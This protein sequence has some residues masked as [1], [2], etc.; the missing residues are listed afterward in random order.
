MVTIDYRDL[1]AR[2][3][4]AAGAE[5]GGPATGTAARSQSPGTRDTRDAA[6]HRARHRLHGPEDRLRRGHHPRRPRRRRTGSW[7]SAG[8][9]GSSRR[10]SAKPS[11][12]GTRAAPSPAAPS[13]HPGAKP[14][15]S[16]T[17]PAAAPPAPTTATLLC[18]HHHHVIH[19]EHWS[20]QVRTGIPWFIPPPHIDPRQRPR[21]NHYFRPAEL[22]AP[23]PEPRCLRLCCLNLPCPSSADG[24]GRTA[25]PWPQRRAPALTPQRSS[26]CGMEP[27]AGTGPGRPDAAEAVRLRLPSRLPSSYRPAAYPCA[28]RGLAAACSTP[29]AGS[30]ATA[31]SGPASSRRPW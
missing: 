28:P 13:P 25:A 6:V 19:K 8:P 11:P 22:S 7:T 27:A 15:T 24:D 31:D 20:I 23:Q 16:T 30:R 3:G 21:R 9:P 4:I 14:T 1:L 26:P 10:T 5:T 17:G 29:V 18:S 12:P 2:L